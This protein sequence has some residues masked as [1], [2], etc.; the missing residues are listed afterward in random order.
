MRKIGRSLACPNVWFHR[1][2]C[3]SLSLSLSLSLPPPSLHRRESAATGSNDSVTHSSKRRAERDIF[4][5]ISVDQARPAINQRKGRIG[6]NLC[7]DTD[8]SSSPRKL[9]NP[10]NFRI[11]LC[12]LRSVSPE[13]GGKIH[14]IQAKYRPS[15]ITH[16]AFRTSSK[17]R[18]F[19]LE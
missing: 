17:I 5:C 12:H 18:F 19:S 3:Q 4:V 11:E 7:I 13:G 9:G 15:C 2:G 14:T 16:A 1:R 10:L 6:F 8:P